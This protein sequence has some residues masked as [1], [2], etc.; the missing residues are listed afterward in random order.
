MAPNL[1]LMVIRS[2]ESKRK[3]KRK[4]TKTIKR[5][6]RLSALPDDILIKILSCLPL[7]LA[8]A[9]ACLSSRWRDLW[10]KVTS[11]HID[12]N[13]FDYSDDFD[14]TFSDII[15]R[16]TSPF[17]HSFSVELG[18]VWHM[19]PYRNYINLDY[20]WLRQICD[21]NVRQLKVTNTRNISEV[22]VSK[23]YRIDILHPTMSK[24]ND[25]FIQPGLTLPSFIFVTQSLVSIELDSTTI[26]LQLPDD[27]DQINL[28]NLNKLH[29][30]STSMNSESLEKLI[31]ACPSLEEF[32]FVYKY[33]QCPYNSVRSRL[34]RNR[35]TC[36]WYI[37]F[38]HQN[39]QRLFIKNLPNNYRVVVNAPK[40]AYLAIHASK[41]AGFRFEEEPMMLSCEAKIHLA[42]YTVY[43]C[44][45]ALTEDE[46]KSMTKFYGVFSNI[47]IVSP[48][49]F[50]LKN[51]WPSNMF[52]NA[53][54][55][56]ISMDMPSN[57][58]ILWA[59]LEL[60]PV[61]DVLTL[62]M[63]DTEGMEI[64]D[65]EMPCQVG[66]WQRVLKKVKIEIN[67]NSNGKTTKALVELVEY[68]LSN[69]VDLKQFHV[70]V[71][72]S[73]R[74]MGSTK[75]AAIRE[76]KL[77]QLLYQCPLL[78]E[79]CEVEFVGRFFKMSRKAGLNFLIANGKD[80]PIN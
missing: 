45:L 77:C 10:T 67:C 16:I 32:G 76:M 60:C 56:T 62:K 28:P 41:S 44:D 35:S 7:Q 38:S 71:D 5:E 31:K 69:S 40:L 48:E 74:K 68:L 27:G 15:T 2:N 18:P 25:Y 19:S 66:T 43:D 17:I 54:Q 21:R 30:C 23:K 8:M 37:N 9:T 22:D 39:L 79:G 59:I 65:A 26:K 14:S 13:K 36:L 55:L 58:N 64:R 63:Q 11:I 49:V 80:S 72:S 4:R 1:L 20:S 42:D 73:S 3:R 12:T 47:T 51:S 34:G 46:I 52:C 57:V 61:L 29:L 33:C 70:T 78:S 53:T 24:Y 75:V 50:V 6:D